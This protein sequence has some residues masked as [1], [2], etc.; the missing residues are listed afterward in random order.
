MGGALTILC[1]FD[2]AHNSSQLEVN[3]DCNIKAIPI[4]SPRTGNQAF[5]NE[6]QKIGRIHCDRLVVDNDPIPKIP[7][8]SM[9]YKHVGRKIRLHTSKDLGILGKMNPT[10]IHHYSNYLKSI[11]AT[12]EKI[13]L[14]FEEP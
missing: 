11:V 4:A 12:H 3:N 5:H 7:L 10:K 9:G 14:S 1:A 13:M 8:A 6:F 2:L